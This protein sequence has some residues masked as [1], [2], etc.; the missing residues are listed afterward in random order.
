MKN[1]TKHKWK[2]I[3]FMSDE[4]LSRRGKVL[5]YILCI[6]FIEVLEILTKEEE[7]RKES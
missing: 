7:E 5:I 3:K 4:Y 2:N 1:D 6:H